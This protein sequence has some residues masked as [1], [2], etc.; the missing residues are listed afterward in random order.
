MDPNLIARARL[1]GQAGQAILMSDVKSRAEAR[2]LSVRTCYADPLEPSVAIVFGQWSLASGVLPA[3]PD[4]TF[5]SAE[6]I[7]Q[8]PPPSFLVPSSPYDR[9][10]PYD[11]MH[12]AEWALKKEFDPQHLRMFGRTFLPDY[13]VAAS[14]LLEKGRKRRAPSL[15]FRSPSERDFALALQALEPIVRQKGQPHVSEQVR[16]AWAYLLEEKPLVRIPES[17]K[18]A[19]V[20]T[21]P[22]RIVTK[23]ASERLTIPAKPVSGSAIALVELAR[24]DPR[25]RARIEEIKQAAREGKDDGLQALRELHRACQLLR[26][27]RWI[28]SYKRKEAVESESGIG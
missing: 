1:Q 24:R 11:E 19:A 12:A 28:L 8:P 10:I 22:S 13:P 21:A 2:G 16:D 26:R 17:V 4:L 9:D 18:L 27:R 15:E 14:L 7:E 3:G 5:L 20:I 25:A 6:P 23:E